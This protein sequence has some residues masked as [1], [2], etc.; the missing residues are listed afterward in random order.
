MKRCCN[1]FSVFVMIITSLRT[2]LLDEVQYEVTTIK[3][4]SKYY[5][6]MTNHLMVTPIYDDDVILCNDDIILW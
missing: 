6:M 3:R 4:R 5:V 1:V 2:H